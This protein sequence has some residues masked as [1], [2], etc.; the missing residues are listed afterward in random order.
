MF[1]ATL[2]FFHEQSRPDR[3]K[4]VKIY[5]QNILKG[6]KCPTL[7]I[8]IIV[9][10]IMIVFHGQKI[11]DV[12]PAQRNRLTSISQINAAIGFEKKRMERT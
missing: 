3:D 7:R 10:K 4:Y 9:P 12:A 2:G 5:W 11:A 1:C 6:K 8:K